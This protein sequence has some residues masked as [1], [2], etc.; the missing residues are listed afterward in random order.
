LADEHSLGS[1]TSGVEEKEREE[2]RQPNCLPSPLKDTG[3][4]VTM[5]ILWCLKFK[6]SICPHISPSSLAKEP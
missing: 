3:I 5:T 1:P 6:G 4:D 2:R